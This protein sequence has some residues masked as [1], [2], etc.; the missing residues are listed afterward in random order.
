MAGFDYLIHINT[1]DLPG[2]FPNLVKPNDDCCISANKHCEGLQ[3][4]ESW[5]YCKKYEHPVKRN[6]AGQPLK[7]FFCK[8]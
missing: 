4:V 3:R 2:R 7:H 1:K 8:S 5:E 6:P